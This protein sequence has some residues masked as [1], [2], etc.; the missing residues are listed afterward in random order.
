MQELSPFV[1][2][3]LVSLQSFTNRENDLKIL[4]KNLVSGINT[5]IISPRRWGKVFTC[6]KSNCRIKQ[7]NSHL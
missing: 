5:I 2:G 1:F 4:K 7:R 6:R 3:N